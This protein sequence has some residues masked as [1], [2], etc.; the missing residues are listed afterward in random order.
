MPAVA[1]DDKAEKND[2]REKP[3]RLERGRRTR[4]KREPHR[5][6]REARA[7]AGFV[8][9]AFALVALAT[10]RADAAG[11]VVAGPSIATRGVIHVKENEALIEELRLAVSQAVAEMEAVER[12]DRELLSERMRFTVRRFVN[13]RFQRK[14][15]VLPM[16]LE[17]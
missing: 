9:A 13:Q 8:I 6:M 1:N 3:G 12:R 10:Y 2:R 4:K 15:V 7:I 16:I 5:W 14:P 17:A 11:A